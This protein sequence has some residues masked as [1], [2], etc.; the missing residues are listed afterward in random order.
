M[1][2]FSHCSFKDLYPHLNCWLEVKLITLEVVI[3]LYN[4]TQSKN[5]MWSLLC[6]TY[7]AVCLDL[8]WPNNLVVVCSNCKKN[9]PW[10]HLASPW[11]HMQISVLV[12]DKY[13]SWGQQYW[14]SST[15]HGDLGFPWTLNHFIQSEGEYLGQMVESWTELGVSKRESIRQ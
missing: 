15:F 14:C 11:G 13:P 2:V 5:M 10:R 6:L 12:I 1:Y 8:K 9:F 3:Y 7:G 4:S